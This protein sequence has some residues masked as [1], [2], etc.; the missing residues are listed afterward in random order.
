MILPEI[1]PTQ[2]AIDERNRLEYDDA[3]D[4]YWVLTVYEPTHG[5]WF[6]SS[7]GGKAVLDRISDEA[8]LTPGSHA[9]EICCG[10]GDTCR[11]T[12]LKTGCS[13]TGVELNRHQIAR[14]KRRQTNLSPELG[15]RL[16]FICADVQLW[17]PER[18]YDAIYVIE[19]L[20]CIEQR[21]AVIRSCI[22]GLGRGRPFFMAEVFAGPNM[23]PDLAK[24][25]WD[26]DGILNLPTAQ[27]QQFELEA[28]GFRVETRDLTPLAV[29]CFAVMACESERHRQALV[30]AK[31]EAR[32]RRWLRNAGIYREA[33][34]NGS[35]VYA[36]SVAR[37]PAD[38]A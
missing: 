8:D 27:Q 5:G 22:A 7:I 4:P 38:A 1:H 12:A 19:G 11:Y 24:F 34:A 13:V 16:R 33:F 29:N 9:L 37:K 15:A 28:L 10:M 2:E 18:Y 26:E 35:L 21:S 20:M 30:D 32:Y 25:I 31:G 3:A 23:T 36:L 17:T 6:F 14:A